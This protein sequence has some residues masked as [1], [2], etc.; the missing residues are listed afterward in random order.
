MKRYKPAALCL[1]LENLKNYRVIARDSFVSNTVRRNI[2]HKRY[3][4]IAAGIHR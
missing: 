4:P 3:Y 1:P 2:F